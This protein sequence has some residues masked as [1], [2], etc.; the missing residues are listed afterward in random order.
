[1]AKRVTATEAKNRLGAL[2]E[3][4]N[5]NNDDVI[6]ESRGEPRAVIITFPEYQQLEACREKARRE[7]LWKQMEALRKRVGEQLQ[8]LS[9]DDVQRI[10]EEVADDA[11]A[12]GMK[13]ERIR[14]KD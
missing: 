8:D 11:I 5:D 7:E 2:M 1:M 12:R 9:S 6:V 3:Y 10:A 14:F 13:S 4:I